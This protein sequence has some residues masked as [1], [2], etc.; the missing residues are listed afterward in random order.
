MSEKQAVKSNLELEV[1]IVDILLLVVDKWKILVLFAAFFGVS[2]VFYSL[3]LPAIYSANVLMS[4]AEENAQK[5]LK[6]TEKEKNRAEKEL[7]KRKQREI[8]RMVEDQDAIDD[9]LKDSGIN[10]V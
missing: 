5:D 3:S 4:E 10:E 7:E 2:G 1:S 9:A 8:L 6:R